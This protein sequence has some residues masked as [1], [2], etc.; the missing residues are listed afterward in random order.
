MNVFR[1]TP[2]SMINCKRWTA[3]KFVLL[4]KFATGF[5][6]KSLY[7][8]DDSEIGIISLLKDLLTPYMD[9]NLEIDAD[10]HIEEFAPMLTL[11][12]TW[13]KAIQHGSSN[14]II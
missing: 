14:F 1:F 4:L 13:I 7:T 12:F 5:I 3:R 10:N 2:W 8:E 6:H 11:A 9:L